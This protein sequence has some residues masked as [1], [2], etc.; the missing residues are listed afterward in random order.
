VVISTY[1]A[2]ACQALPP[3]LAHFR[4]SRP[5]V[6]V[7]L[8]EGRQ[9]DI[10]DDVR[11]GV[12]DF[13][14]G[15]VNALP[16]TL[17]S[18]TLRREPLC[19]MVPASHSLARARPARLAL[20]ALRRHTL[21]ALPGDSYSRRLVDGAAAR[22]GFALRYSTIVTRFES[23]VQY[24]MS[25]AGLGIVPAGAL[26]PASQG[27]HAAPLVS[28]ALTVT[29]GVITRRASYMTPA[30]ARLVSLITERVGPLERR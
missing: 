13:G 20:A 6:E 14:V 10:V 17:Q 19:V 21:V 4:D 24:V 15:F 11:S 16:E 27:F 23:V 29:L 3:I 18:T 25:G 5:Q 2:F 8:R 12:A 22:R 28:P 30:A 7:R 26:P 9:P 1:S